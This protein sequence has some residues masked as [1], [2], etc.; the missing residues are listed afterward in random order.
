MN[1]HI[2]I[3]GAGLTGLTTAFRLIP[4][5]FRITIVEKNALGEYLPNDSH[6]N[7]EYSTGLP[8]F[9]GTSSFPFVLHRFQIATWTLLKELGT[10]SHLQ[11]E[12][13][14]RFEFLRSVDH[15]I[16]FRSFPAPSPF[17]TLLGLL[18]FRKLSLRDR[19]SLINMLEKFW[20]GDNEFPREL[21][22]QTTESW[23]R[24]M[25]Q[26]SLACREVWNP[27]CQFFLRESLA[28]SSAHYFSEMIRKCFLSARRNVET[29]IPRY[30]ETF[31]LLKPLKKLLVQ[32]GATFC[33]LK[34]AVQIQCGSDR[35]LGVTLKDGTTLTA[36]EYVSTI[37][38]NDLVT[39]L[40]DRVLAK[41]SY[42][43]NLSKF[44][45]RS[46]LMVQLRMRFAST[47]PRLLLSSKTFPWMT[48]RPEPDHPPG[49]TLVSCV[50]TEDPTLHSPTDN[51]LIEQ[52]V[53]E[54]RNGL[55]P[56]TQKENLVPL[57][58]HV[59]RYSHAISASQPG[60]SGLRP[61][62]QSPMTNFYLAG[63]WTDTGLPSSRESSI[64][65]GETCAQAIVDSRQT[66]SV[67]NSI[68][69]S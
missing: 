17:H 63:P 29:H 15:P 1:R 2:I 58:A 34:E 14:V 49:T 40:P 22:T 35:I 52:A 9:Q 50:T 4:H 61:L 54:I 46:E 43:C 23:L 69:D 57:E 8:P 56:Q 5:G 51:G 60:I 12:T 38:P 32:K 59:V 55:F 41:F 25:G 3:I 24:S 67:D 10:A 68:H 37:P 48:M 65:S 33:S 42:F 13:P 44:P 11:H 30:D 45:E 27:L 20:E 39:C 62:Q 64:V 16:A 21:D 6:H 66:R 31:L 19:W 47:R 28:Q 53:E 18:T 7:L 26:S 36:D